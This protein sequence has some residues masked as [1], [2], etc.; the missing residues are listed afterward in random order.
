MSMA[1]SYTHL[2]VYKRQVEDTRLW[3]RPT[4]D[5]SSAQTGSS[6]FDFDGDGQAEVVY[7]DETT[8]HVYAGATGEPLFETCSTNGTL[9]EYPLVA[10][11]D[12]DGHADI[13]VGS[14]SYSGFTCEDGSKTTGIRV[15]GD[16]EGNWVRTRRVWN[17]HAYHVTNVEESGAIPAAEASNHEVPGLN[18]FRQNVQPSGQFSAPDLVVSIAPECDGEGYALRARVLNVGE[19]PVEAG[20]VVGFYRGGTQLGQLATT[21]ALYPLTFEDLELALDEEIDDDVRA[22]VDDGA[23]PHPWHEC[24]TD[25]NESAAVSGACPDGPN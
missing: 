10:D 7:A 3:L 21:R 18:N 9:W 16:L 5:C 13:I 19:A 2:D 14:N 17:Q 23:P 15:F 22:V 8:M 25:N 11:V 20:V 4:Q 1:V 6:V 12:N 24:R